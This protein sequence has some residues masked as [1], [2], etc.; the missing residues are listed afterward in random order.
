MIEIVGQSCNGF[1]QG[2]DYTC[3]AVYFDGAMQA[4]IIGLLDKNFASVLKVFSSIEFP[5]GKRCMI[6]S[7][8][9]YGY[10]LY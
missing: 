8:R 9:S 7:R 5:A 4:A 1:L 10:H 2:S 6:C 3:I